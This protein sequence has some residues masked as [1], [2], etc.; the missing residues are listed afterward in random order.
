MVYYGSAIQKAEHIFGSLIEAQ[1]RKVQ[2]IQDHPPEG[3]LS[4]YILQGYHKNA[5]HIVSTRKKL[6]RENKIDC[7]VENDALCIKPCTLLSFL[8]TQPAFQWMTSKKMDRQLREEGGLTH[9]A[10]RRAATKRI[11]GERYLELSFEILKASS[12][13]YG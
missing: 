12:R 7:V 8:K 9:C 6:E 2:L 3:N 13:K 1:I 11:N 4:W 5:F 10:E